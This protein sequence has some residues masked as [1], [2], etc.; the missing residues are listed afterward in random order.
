MSLFKRRKAFSSTTETFN[1][2]AVGQICSKEEFIRII[3][4]ER[5]RAERND[6]CF[7][8]ILFDTAAIGLN[9]GTIGP[10]TQKIRHRIRQ[11]DQIGWYDRQRIGLILPYT[12]NVGACQLAAHICSDVEMSYSPSIC[13]V[14]TYPLDRTLT[15][16][17]TYPLSG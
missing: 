12:S 5:A 2:K 7:S 13:H 4:N 9:P 16:T 1:K 8:L 17:T 6:H 14:N 11:V 3:A 15:K 10:F